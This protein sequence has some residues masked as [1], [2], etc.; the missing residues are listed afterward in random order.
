[1]SAFLGAGGP[2]GRGADRVERE[3]AGAVE[4]VARDHTRTFA[5]DRCRTPFAVEQ[6]A[7][8]LGYLV[9]GVRLSR[10]STVAAIE[11]GGHDGQ[12]RSN[13]G[14]GIGGPR[15]FR[16]VRNP[17]R[18]RRVV[19]RSVAIGSSSLSEQASV[20]AAPPV[21]DGE[22]TAGRGQFPRRTCHTY[23]SWCGSIGGH[24]PGRFARVPGSTRIS[25][26]NREIFR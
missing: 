6:S 21:S 4:G 25:S 1:M 2:D 3:R 10:R 20:A 18:R 17:R 11:Y 14:L 22:S 12:G 9:G 19:I 15:I 16:N 23:S 13:G 26:Q 24:V 8:A 5:A 7:G